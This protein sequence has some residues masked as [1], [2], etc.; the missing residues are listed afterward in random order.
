M[1]SPELV[2]VTVGVI[3]IVVSIAGGIRWLVKHYL[4]ELKPDGNGGHNL[5]G[6][7]RRMESRIDDLYRVIVEQQGRS[8]RR[9]A[10]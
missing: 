7:I 1:P 8:T 10:R 6:R 9:R 4:N 5:E 3:S 2:A